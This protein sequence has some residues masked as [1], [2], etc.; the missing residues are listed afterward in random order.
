[1]KKVFKFIAPNGE[2]VEWGEF[3]DKKRIVTFEVKKFCDDGV[4]MET[5]QL[6]FILPEKFDLNSTLN[7]V[8]SY[9]GNGF[10]KIDVPD[11]KWREEDTQEDNRELLTD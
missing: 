5:E 11:Q 2:Y 8:S 9:H 4:L 3:D 10:R 1:M 6:D 7:I